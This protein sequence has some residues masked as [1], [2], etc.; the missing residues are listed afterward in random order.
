V[1]VLFQDAETTVEAQGAKPLCNDHG[2][3]FGILLQQFGD[4]GFKGIQL[5]RRVA[6][7]RPCGP[8]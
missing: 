3:G 2:A 1:Q 6:G 4:G 7:E 8:A 5:A